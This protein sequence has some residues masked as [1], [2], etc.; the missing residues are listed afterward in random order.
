MRFPQLKTKRLHLREIRLKDDQDLFA[1]LSDPEVTKY[2]G[3]EPLKTKQGAV[4]EI[5]W[6]QKIFRE[7]SG[8]RWGISLRDTP[9]LIG[10]CG[11]HSWNPQHNRVEVGYELSRAFW[12]AGIMSEALKKIIQYG[13]FSC[14]F[15]RIQAVVDPRNTASL[16]VLQKLGFII[17][18]LLNEYEYV[19]EAFD[20]L[21]MLALLRKD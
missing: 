8:I 21:L 12:G 3:M 10:T 7:K 9:T 14:K 15:N 20:D 11:F 5:E 16:V 13:F 2:Y 18:G 6:Y 19:A 17:E 1:V 4:Q